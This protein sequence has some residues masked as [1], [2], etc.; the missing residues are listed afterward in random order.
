MGNSSSS[1]AVNLVHECAY[2]ANSCNHLL[3]IILQKP[4]HL[5]LLCLVQVTKLS[6]D[7]ITTVNICQEQITSLWSY[8]TVQSGK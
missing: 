2:R 3:G 4:I 1:F 7:F 8:D 5:L 6:L